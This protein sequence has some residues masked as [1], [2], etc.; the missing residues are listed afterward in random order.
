MN[1]DRYRHAERALW[2]STGATPT[3][4]TIALRRTGT[5]VRIQEVGAGP[6]VIFVHGAANGGTSWASLV[7]RLDG[8]RCIVIDRPGCGLSPR[9]AVRHDDVAAL[10]AFADDLVVDV[11]DA[12]GVAQ[13][14]VVGTS[15]GGYFALRAAAAHPDRIDRLVTLSW[16]FGA[17]TVA[18]PFVMRIAMQPVLGRLVMRVPITER[19][20]RLLLKQIGLRRAVETGRFGPVEMAWFLSL[21]RDTDTMRNEIDATPRIVTLRG[22]NEATRLP[23]SLLAKVTSPSYFLWGEE[24]PMGGSEI[25]RQF[26]TNFPD[27]ELELLP[28]AGHAP[29]IDAPDHVADRV[30]SFLRREPLAR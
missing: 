24:D 30:G 9:S 7:A 23:P 20:A 21:L 19:M 1:E 5:S 18:T 25:A 2:A 17:P 8:F 28:R 6:A 29:W 12:V 3:E 16:S 13:A 26:V 15:F 14:H 27:A 10:G 4:R 22:F 11:L